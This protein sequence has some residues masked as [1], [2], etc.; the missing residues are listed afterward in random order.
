MAPKASGYKSVK[1]SNFN[2]VVSQNTL[3]KY[4]LEI[5]KNYLWYLRIDMN[6]VDFLIKDVCQISWIAC[7]SVTFSFVDV[8][9]LDRS[10]SLSLSLSISLFSMSFLYFVS[11]NVYLL[12]EE[13]FENSDLIWC[14]PDRHISRTFRK[15][16][17][18]TWAVTDF[19]SPPSCR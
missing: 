10:L 6:S 11:F 18:I 12:K 8:K 19:R 1:W 14:L 3:T 16:V 17:F 15:E 5:L 4:A 2:I 7:S 13:K 9:L